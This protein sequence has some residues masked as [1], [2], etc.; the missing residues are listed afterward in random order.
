MG[1]IL[2]QPDNSLE[3]ITA[4]THLELPGEFIFD[5]TH[6]FPRLMPVLFNSR[7]NLGHEQDY[8]SFVS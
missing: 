4:I 7:A 2:M 1:F 3:S 5:Y 8:H 6:S